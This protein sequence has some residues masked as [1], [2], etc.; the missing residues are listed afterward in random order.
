MDAINFSQG[1]PS[2]SHSLS[3]QPDAGAAHRAS[4]EVLDLLQKGNDKV[5]P[6]A[7]VDNPCG[8]GSGGP[9]LPQIEIVAPT[10]GT[11]GAGGVER[12][13]ADNTEVGT[14]R[15]GAAEVTETHGAIGAAY[16]HQAL[17]RNTAEP[18]S[19]EMPQLFH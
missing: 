14:R 19:I 2:D 15:S 13:P 8:S 11:G 4:N 17:D 18:K 10:S 1:T 7:A 3:H 6:I 12:P 9:M 5:T 16:A